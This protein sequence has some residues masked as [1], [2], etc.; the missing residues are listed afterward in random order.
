MGRQWFR[1]EVNATTVLPVQVSA[2]PFQWA[3]FLRDAR[4]AAQPFFAAFLPPAA[5]QA[6]PAASLA[7]RAQ[8]QGPA[9]ARAGLSE[10]AVLTAVIAAVQAALGEEVGSGTPL[11]QAGLDS[12]GENF[13]NENCV[14]WSTSSHQNIIHMNQ[15][16]CSCKHAQ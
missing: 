12:L 2:V 3:T 13:W 15:V 7:A 16:S 9:A 11:L 8:A 6:E 10:A 1:I 4:Q 5:Q 14:I